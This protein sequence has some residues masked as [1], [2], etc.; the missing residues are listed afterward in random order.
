MG[1]TDTD[2]S[3]TLQRKHGGATARQEMQKHNSS[4]T[5]CKHM[6]LYLVASNDSQCLGSLGRMSY[7]LK[8]YSLKPVFEEMLKKI[9]AVTIN[10][11]G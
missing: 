11:N 7:Y 9:I 1:N 8:K 2:Q 3:C 5:I 10:I 6:K 4:E